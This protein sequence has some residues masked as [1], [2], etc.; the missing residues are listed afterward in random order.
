MTRDS[1]KIF[2]AYV[3]N[4]QPAQQGQQ[5]KQVVMLPRANFAKAQIQGLSPDKEYHLLQVDGEDGQNLQVRDEKGQYKLP[6]NLVTPAPQKTE[7]FM[8]YFNA[9]QST[10]QAASGQPK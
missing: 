9:N 6:K 2:E 5:Q 8:K 4:Q 1:I 3:Q 7:E 10:T